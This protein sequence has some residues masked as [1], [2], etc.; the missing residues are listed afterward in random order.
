MFKAG[1]TKT[2]ENTK[3]NLPSSRRCTQL[4]VRDFKGDGKKPLHIK[5]RLSEVLE[6]VYVRKSCKCR[7]A[8]HSV[9]LRKLNP[10][11]Q[12]DFFFLSSHCT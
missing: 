8:Q 7:D 3:L 4:V 10:E 1:K 5:E 11:T 6:G 9:T 2:R 12:F